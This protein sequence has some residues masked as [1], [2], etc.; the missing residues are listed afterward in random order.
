[1]NLDIYNN[2]RAV[3][4]EAKKEIRGGRLNGKT[5]IN[6]MWRIKKLTEQFG[7]CGIGWKYTIDREWLETRGQRGNLRIHGHLTVLQI[8]RRVVRGSSR[9]RRQRLYHKKRR[10]VCTPLTSAT[11]WP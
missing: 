1:M 11:R 8:Q 10:A 3:P 4:A 7:P 6:P 2:V 9:Y 5:D